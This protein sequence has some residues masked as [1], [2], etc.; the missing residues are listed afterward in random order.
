[1]CFKKNPFRTISACGFESLNIGSCNDLEIDFLND[2][3]PKQKL[4]EEK[5]KLR[6]Q[7]HEKEDF[8]QNLKLVNMYR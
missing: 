3:L 7:V 4:N 8:L 1:M 2:T 5:T 6:K